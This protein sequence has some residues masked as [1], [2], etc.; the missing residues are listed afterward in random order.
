MHEK[1]NLNIPTIALGILLFPGKRLRYNSEINI[2]SKSMG[3]FMDET[4]FVGFLFKLLENYKTNAPKNC[5]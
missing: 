3:H 2:L 1:E 4:N 5:Y